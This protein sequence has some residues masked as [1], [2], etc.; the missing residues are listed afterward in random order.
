MT[1]VTTAFVTNQE[2]ISA[3]KCSASKRQI[4]SVHRV[5]WDTLSIKIR[6][7][8]HRV[9]CHNVR[10]HVVPSM[11]W[12]LWVKW[13]VMDIPMRIVEALWIVMDVM[14][15]IMTVPVLRLTVLWHLVLNQQ[16]NKSMTKFVCFGFD[17]FCFV[18]FWIWIWIY[19][20]DC[21]WIQSHWSRDVVELH[22]VKSI[23][24]TLAMPVVVAIHREDSNTL[25]FVRWW[26]VLNWKPI[27]VQNV[28]P[29]IVWMEMEDAPRTLLNRLMVRSLNFVS[30]SLVTTWL[31]WLN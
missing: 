26:N 5:I 4:H 25:E 3:L 28:C 24:R 30:K 10:I 17:F 8:V 27:N 15:H 31:T 20:L 23:K 11:P 18:L 9:W 14:P 6:I 1:D 29:G 19:I 12:Q 21:D 7:N 13:N 16:V 22:F 2:W